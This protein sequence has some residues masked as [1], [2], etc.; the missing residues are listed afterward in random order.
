MT[1]EPVEVILN[2]EKTLLDALV[3][4]DLDFPLTPAEVK[5]VIEHINDIQ[6]IEQARRA[7][8]VLGKLTIALTLE[9]NRRIEALKE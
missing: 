8:K 6:T 7:F 3:A 9:L 1:F 2:D 5:F 4:A